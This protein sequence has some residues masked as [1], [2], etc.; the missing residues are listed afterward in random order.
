MSHAVVW[1]DLGNLYENSQRKAQAIDA[2]RL[3]LRISEPIVARNYSGKLRTLWRLG[4]LLMDEGRYAE[5]VNVFRTEWQIRKEASPVVPRDVADSAAVFAI[6]LNRT[7]AF[8]EAQQR[9]SDVVTIYSANKLPADGV[10]A[11]VEALLGEMAHRQNNLNEAELHFKRAVDLFG[12][13]GDSGGE[14]WCNFSL[15][16]VRFEKKDYVEA[17]ER[18]TRLLKTF[19]TENHLSDRIYTLSLL[20]SVYRQSD[21]ATQA[22]AVA[23]A[24]SMDCRS[25]SD[26]W[27]T[28]ACELVNAFGWL[29]NVPATRPSSD[30]WTGRLPPKPQ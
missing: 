6:S 13:A 23:Q 18:L 12:S 21:R 10:L 8:A 1:A 27:D 9:A 25:A 29:G 16:L 2:Y 17:E 22:D 15:A 4:V 11:G 19:S 7:R 30:L 14:D 5:A 26:W 28:N 20:S 3:A 24:V